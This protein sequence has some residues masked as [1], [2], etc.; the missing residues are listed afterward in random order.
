MNDIHS[1]PSPTNRLAEP[2]TLPTSPVLADELVQAAKRDDQSLIADLNQWLQPLTAQQRVSW[3]LQ[4]LPGHHVLSS[5]FGIQAALMLHLVSRQLPDIPV[6]L[7]DTGYLFPETYRF[8]DQLTQQLTLNLQIYRAK[9]S[10]A[11]QEAKYGQLWQQGEAGLRR[12]NQLNKVEPMARALAEHNAGCWFAGLRRS[13]ADSRS[14]LP[15][16]ALK[17]GRFKLLP[18]ID[19]DN[20]RVHQYLQQHHLPYH[21]LWQEGYVSV[22]DWHSSAPLS[23]GMTEEQTRFNG[24]TRE[25][26][27]HLDL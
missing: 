20:R 8:I 22:G 16:L 9:L 1:N 6:L 2:V 19:W 12:Y 18:V 3:A 11:W 26:G 25:C 27:L 13:Q 7:T 15:V 10:P 21:P 17:A 4:T 14:S 5:S 23:S 24:M